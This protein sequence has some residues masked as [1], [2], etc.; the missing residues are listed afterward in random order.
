MAS[1][2]KALLGRKPALEDDHAVLR[3]T[4]VRREKLVDRI[5]AFAPYLRSLLI[6][7]GLLYTLALPYKDLGRK[8]YISENALQPGQVNTYWN[9]ADVHIADIYADK[10]AKWSQED[11]SVEQRTKA[12]QSVLQEL[13]LSTSRQAYSY[14]LPGNATI[15]GI[16]TY[17]ILH[18]PK[19]DG[20]EALVLS[21][22]WLSRATH[23]TGH[24]RI[25]SRGVALVLALANYFK[26]HSMW[27]KDIIFVIGDDYV[28]GT[29]AWLD[30]YHGFGQD[31]LH[32]EPLK[33]TTGPI[34]AALNLDYPHHSF[35]HAGI[36]Y[37]GANGHLPN[38][39]F[40][41]S[42]S[43]I[44]RNMGIPPL[45]HSHDPA[46]TSAL[47]NFLASLPFVGHSEVQRYAHAARNLIRQ[48]AL[49][50]DGRILGPEGT[51]GKYRIDAITLFGVPAEG[52]HGFHSLGRATESLF[53]TLNNLLERFHQSFFLYIMTSV[54]SFIAVGNYLAAPVLLG[55]GMT[56]QGLMTWAEADG[57]EK[58]DRSVARALAVVAIA[59]AAGAAELRMLTGL[60]PTKE[61]NEFLASLLL[62][63]HLLVPLL[64]STLFA[65]PSL[66]IRLSHTLHSLALLLSGLL[67]SVTAT[68][69]FGLSLISALHLALVLVLLRPLA[70]RFSRRQTAVRRAQQLLLAAASPTGIWSLWRVAQR[71]EAEVWARELLRD[72]HVGGGWSLPVAL[73]L[74]GPL[75]LVHSTAILL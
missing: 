28:V 63:L 15:S 44:L 52:P 5:L 59:V 61:L 60:D 8:H 37:E 58:R 45:L 31:N 30:A 40:I 64:L 29:Q 48:V 14:E 73:A 43:R 75:V 36:Y 1:R 35:S 67:V 25:N 71:D 6:L 41:N 12:A 18:A 2:L 50:A 42:A 24:P 53:R 69:N 74:V 16:N 46:R 38:L 10:V 26:K 70:H 49:T 39:D 65:H 68:L 34:W 23:E 21:A 57:R 62:G 66:S 3:R 19:T 56:I 7:A 47:P 9:W 17:A 22:S 54:D 72:W 11:V 33:L 51:F 55:A 27:S 32:A 13:G 4:L 20:A